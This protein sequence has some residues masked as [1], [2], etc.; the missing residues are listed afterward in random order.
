MVLPAKRNLS[1]VF[2]GRLQAGRVIA[3]QSFRKRKTKP[4]PPALQ[5][6]SPGSIRKSNRY[7][8]VADYAQRAAVGFALLHFCRDWIWLFCSAGQLPD[9]LFTTSAKAIPSPS[10]VPTWG[11]TFSGKFS[12][13]D[14]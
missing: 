14:Q 7:R 4:S 1:I 11:F 9:T 6:S 2:E 5:R 10:I 3:A 13:I 8:R 12:C